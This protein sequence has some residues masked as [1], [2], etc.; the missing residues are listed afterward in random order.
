MR[1]CTEA[2]RRGVRYHEDI[3]R[4]GRAIALIVVDVL[5]I[6]IFFL[7]SA[8]P[9]LAVDPDPLRYQS[10]WGERHGAS[11]IDPTES[12][13]GFETRYEIQVPPGRLGMQ[14]DLSLIY[15]SWGNDNTSPFGYGWNVSIPFIER[16][17]KKGTNELYTSGLFSSSLDGELASTTGSFYGAKYEGGAFRSYEFASSSTYWVVTDKQGVT[18]T[19][20][21]TAGARQDKPTDST[22]VFR[23]MLE[24]VR[25][26]N[27]NFIRYEY[28]KDQGQIYP[29]K[30]IYTGYNTTDGIFEV[31]FL[32]ENRS[33]ALTSG[34]M[35]FMATTSSRISE[36]QAKINGSW[37]RKYEL[38]YS[39]GANS[40][41]ALLTSVIE[42]GKDESGAIITLPATTYTYQGA[43]S[44][45]TAS[46]TPNVTGYFVKHTGHDKSRR[47]I[48]TDGNGIQEWHEA[49][50][51][52]YVPYQTVNGFP[53]GFTYSSGYLDNGTRFFDANGDG[54]TDALRSME[55]AS[56]IGDDGIFEGYQIPLADFKTT[57][58]RSG[59]TWATSTDWAPAMYFA[60]DK[61]GHKDQG[62]R[63]GDFNGDGLVDI[64]K[65]VQSDPNPTVGQGT[66]INTN[67]GQSW[68]NGGYNSIPY[69]VVWADAASVN[70]D[71]GLRFADLNGDGLTDVLRSIQPESTQGDTGTLG[72][73]QGIPI[74]WFKKAYINTG[75][76]W[77]ESSAYTPSTYF[78]NHQ[79]QLL[80][81]GVEFLDINGDGLDD[82]LT[83]HRSGG[84]PNFGTTTVAINTG[85]GF[86][87]G[88][89]PDIPANLTFGSDYKDNG[90]RFMDLNE[91]GLLDAIRLLEPE[92]SDG[93]NGVFDG[94][95]LP[96]SYFRKAYISSG[97]KP[98]LLTKVT[99]SKG[100]QTAVTY[101]SSISLRDSNGTLLNPNLPFPVFVV[102]KI[103][104][105]D[106]LGTVYTD[107]FEYKDGHFYFN[108]PF[109]R[110]Y[111]GFRVI[112][113]TDST[114]AVTKTYFHQGNGDTTADGESGDH[115]ALISKTY[116][117]DILNT[118]GNLF[119]RA[120]TN[121]NTTSLSGG[122][123]Y[124]AKVGET[125]LTYD[126][127]SD[128]RDIATEW[129]F[130]TTNGNLATSTEWGEVTASTTAYDFSD[131]G[132][133]KRT[134][135]ISYSSKS[136]TEMGFPSTQ[137]VYDQDGT[138]KVKEERF[139][140]DSLSLGS[141]DKGNET[142]REH[143]ITG[144]TY[145][146]TEKTYNS[147]GLVTQEKDPR[148][149][150]TTYV[151]DSYNLRVATSTNPLGHVT[152]VYYDLS[153]GQAATTTDPNGRVF[154]TVFDAL[155]RV[156][157]QKEPD[158][159]TPTTLVAVL[160]SEYT[161]T[162]GSRLIKETRYLNAATSTETYNYLDG[163]DRVRQ[164]RTEAESSY[165]VS[166]FT[167]D[168]L[169]RVKKE[170]LPYF[171]S[172]SASTTATTDSSLY[173]TFT[174]DPLGRISSIVNALGTTSHTYDQWETITTD[175]NGDAK[176]F[177]H[178]A[179]GNLSQVEEHNSGNTYTTAYTYDKNNNLTRITDALSN[180]RNFTY[181]GLSRLT[182]S[183]DLH[184]SGDSTF[185]STTLYYDAAG[186]LTDRFTDQFGGTTFS[187]DDI[188]RPLTEDSAA[189][190]GTEISYAYD[191]CA[192]GKGRLCAATTTDAVTNY[193]YYANGKVQTE[194]RAIGGTSYTT[195]YKYDRQGNPTFITYSDLS[196][197]KYNYNAAGLLEQVGQRE[198]GGAFSAL[199]SN[200]DYGPTGA[201]TFKQFVNGIDSTYTY[202]A[203]K[204][205]R[206]TNILTKTGGTGGGIQFAFAPSGLHYANIKRAL[207]SYLALV[208]GDV[209][210]ADNS[211][212]SSSAS[213]DAPLPQDVPSVLE[214]LEATSIDTTTEIFTDLPATT[215][216]VGND[217]A[218]SS[219][220]DSYT[221]T[222]VQNSA[223]TAPQEISPAPEAQVAPKEEKK[224]EVVA[225]KKSGPYEEKDDIYI[226][227]LAE[228]SESEAS[229]ELKKSAPEVRLKKWNGEIDLG[230]AYRKVK[231][232]AVQAA[233]SEKIEWKDEK[234]ELHVYPL[235]VAEGMEEGGFEVEVYLKEK[236]ASNTFTFALSGTENLDFF[237][238]PA[239]SEETPEGQTCTDTQCTDADGTIVSERPENV[240]GSYAVYHKEKAGHRGGGLNYGTGKT[241]HIYRPKAI[242]AQ[243]N[244]A[245]GILQVKNDTLSVEI[246]QSFLDSASYPVRVDPTFG[247]TSLGGSSQTIAD[248][249]S[250]DNERAGHPET[251][252][253][254][255][256]LDSLHAGLKIS[257]TFSGDQ[258][259]S[260][261]VFV[262]DENTSTDSH[263]EAAAV[264]NDKTITSTS[265]SWF[266]FTAS[267][268]P[269]AADTY[270]LN[271]VGD[272]SDLSGI[273]RAE[274]VYDSTGS[275]NNYYE[276][277]T[278]TYDSAKESPWTETDS[279]GSR[280]YSLYATY[281]ASSSNQAPTAP[282]SLWAEGQTDPIDIT[283]STPEFSA[284]YND[285]DSGDLAIHFRLQVATTSDFSALQWDSG[286]TTMATTTTGNRSPDISYAGSALASSTTYYWR[287]AFSDD[288]GA[289]GAWSTATS[290][291]SLAASGGGGGGAVST[292]QNIS[293]TEYDNLNNIKKIIDYSDTGVGKT[294]EYTYDDLSRLLSASTTAASSTPYQRTYVYN[295]LGNITYASDLGAYLYTG[296]Q[297]S[298][299]ANPHAVTDLA[300]TTYSYDQN[301]NMTVAGNTSYTWD[302]RNRLKSVGG[303]ATSTYGYD[304]TSDRVF[305]FAANATTTYPNK[306]YNT[307]GA[308]T[309][310]HIFTPAG[311]LVA[312]IEITGSGGGGG[313][314]T[315]TTGWKTAGTVEVNTGWTNLATSTLVSSDDNRADCDATCDNSDTAQVSD[316]NFGIP[317]GATIDGIEVQWECQGVADSSLEPRTSLS[318]NDGTSF[319]TEEQAPP[320]PS[321]TDGTI[322]MGSATSTWGRVWSASE[323]ADGTFRL[324]IDKETATRTLRIDRLQVKVY[325]T[326]AGG[327]ATSTATTTRFVHTD[328]LG[329]TS[330]VT[331]ST[332]GV[333]SATDFYPY[334]TK[335]IDTAPNV[336]DRQYIGER[337][338]SES[339]LSYLNARYLSSDRGQFLSQDP[340]FNED[341]RL[342]NL[343]NP[344][345]LNSYLYANGNPIVNKDSNGRCVDGISTLACI[346]AWSLLTT[347]V[348]AH[349]LMLYGAIA[350]QPEAIEAGFAL[351]NIGLAGAG[352][353]RGFSNPITAGQKGNTGLPIQTQKEIKQ[354]NVS[355]SAYPESAAHIEKAQSAGFP[356]ILTIDRAGA[357]LR[358]QQSMQGST[359]M[360]K[361][362]RDEYPP[363]MFKEG[364]AG[365]SVKYINP[366]DN[367][368]A[369]ACIGNQCRNVSDGDRVQIN[370][371]E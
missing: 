356:S 210:P 329:G 85:N 189:S 327:G 159:T 26:P 202:D 175:A 314:A 79:G 213:P 29:S 150:A 196:E 75:N 193:A 76:G 9:A 109:D 158:H 10:F 24:E 337:F 13:G 236:P 328:H 344:Q 96:L 281:T 223:D 181:D 107:E 18:Y 321:N 126:G 238:Q 249:F 77:Q 5:F 11:I 326:T 100:K 125:T 32:R 98:D 6:S 195:T 164:K 324:K 123:T 74:A 354:I 303:T 160:T 35:G 231:G 23:W 355:R 199:V 349:G 305:K 225:P 112:T 15:N 258:T 145:I 295:A 369:G 46:S 309:T 259:V 142:K 208:D 116:R 114:G 182:K 180:L 177:R 22:Q 347:I 283:D 14:P 1:S 132:S 28:Y 212:T 350:D 56:T 102:T 190:A 266:T 89:F 200:F 153:S 228:G 194:T 284:I 362:D 317:G 12:S 294:V 3:M 17:S 71:N 45:W 227:K 20:G 311:D 262:N 367:R 95:Q 121:W 135:N 292:I 331:D 49:S 235:P 215:S 50:H 48:D 353:V 42:S 69:S 237:Y 286:T 265:A 70:Y 104:T 139:Y 211:S 115:R 141:V 47:A 253:E 172:G 278:G 140:Y 151:Y 348:S 334:G 291:F 218:T 287:V 99:D 179:Y 302:W 63:F 7:V 60:T 288:S 272:G 53:H 37:V 359:P 340:V 27:N 65:G 247:Y 252:S 203:T 313:S 289:T 73:Y 146:D 83:G 244:E 157:E 186:N 106:G 155:D 273:V 31:E 156:K 371:A 110:T 330:A 358:R 185:A 315:S 113:K 222:P 192:N 308:T 207:E 137:T 154:V 205:Y 34:V 261:K 232:A 263:T 105:N 274:V 57:H 322:T 40:A 206:L 168:A 333:V 52:T 224:P 131:T 117:A 92:S 62:V 341:P 59:S 264:E 87:T 312:T 343:P 280:R 88:L 255:G 187:Y 248:Y 352:G 204:R 268:Q 260:V 97:V 165:A 64:A 323:L 318:W 198:S 319:T 54:R 230:V 241:F 152:E 320:C 279:S 296:D 147:Y 300:S 271:I 167:Y 298:N 188:N 361:F 293:F 269:L 136:G 184:A 68:T 363:A 174:Y 304:H 38:D 19:F 124:Y 138:T 2:L 162:L 118:G 30:I 251:L 226:L 270:I 197:V 171:N 58:L 72:G 360:T 169:N 220:Q 78:V 39:A 101:K 33:D 43:M 119:Q 239:L 82:M 290:T 44:A 84:N 122:R 8:S 221:S 209:L 90:L 245:W 170:G 41:R 338:D 346:G 93:T 148:D 108:N 130:N 214:T 256:T 81:D 335:R 51:S 364:G 201:V 250:D 166:D 66:D 25:D 4:Q 370:I 134:T 86:S 161:D 129:A 128:H 219:P 21:K 368:G 345:I 144:S 276:D 267:S 246:P 336:V 301:G 306:Y 351:N 342:Q 120:F 16:I 242:D 67:N 339:S 178:D 216:T 297:G 316:F 310:R 191:Y 307:T 285:P 103:D 173:S 55:P 233:D 275:R 61:T 80:N 332:G 176:D 357:S 36:V 366:S 365:S 94:Y 149:K 282:T 133:D 240:V 163:F 325:Y 254:A 217:A 111:A 234:E 257:S 277:F 143:W 299:Y 91:D 183:E 243:G 229:V 127:D